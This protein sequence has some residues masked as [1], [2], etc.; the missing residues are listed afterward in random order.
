MDTRHFKLT[1]EAERELEQAEMNCRDVKE[2][3]RIQAVRLF[4][5]G[6]ALTT[7]VK[8]VQASERTIRRWAKRY[9]ERG[10]AGLGQPPTAGNH[11]KLTRTERALVVQTLRE[12][13]PVSVRVSERTQWSVTDVRELV[14]MRHKVVYVG[15]ASYH[16]LLHEAGLSYQHVAKVY[17]H[18]PNAV[19]ISDWQADAEKK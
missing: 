7:L 6:E 4:G 5:S 13:S 16:A 9:D 3:R 1:K 18:Q 19:V 8:V 10:L 2:R 15:A 17:R 11:R 12:A 14:K